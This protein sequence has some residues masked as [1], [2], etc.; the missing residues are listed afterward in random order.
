MACGLALV[1]CAG[2][3]GARTAWAHA[4]LVASTPAGGA[5]LE[6]P[7]VGLA[8]VFS[9]PVQPVAVQVFDPDGNRLAGVRVQAQGSRLQV[10]LPAAARARG[11]YLLSWR[12][13]SADGHPVSGVL[14]YAV[15]AASARPMVPD[16]GRG[17]HRSAIW[18]ARWLTYVCIVV[19]AGAALFRPGHRAD[20][21]AWTR[22]WAGAGLGLLLLD[23]ALQGLDLVG[24][25]WAGLGSSASWSAALAGSYAWTLGLLALALLLAL[26]TGPAPGRANLW[27]AACATPLI[28]AGAFALSGHAAT[29]SP[30]W[31]ARPSVVLHVLMVLAWIGSLWPLARALRRAPAAAVPDLRL[32]R[33]YSIAITWVVALLVASGIVLTSLQLDR[34]SDAWRTGYGR[35]LLAKLV[36]VAWLLL[37]AAANRWRWTGPA[38]AGSGPALRAL[39]RAVVVELVL[40]AV[41]LAVVALWRFTPPPRAMAAVQVRAG[42]AADAGLAAPVSLQD[43]RLQAR[44]TPT[45]GAQ[46]WV[47]ALQTPQGTAFAAQDVTLVL[48]N[49][50]AG[51]GAMRLAAQ[52]A[53]PGQWRVAVPVL[54]LVGRWQP[55]L[56]VLIDDFDQIRL[57]AAPPPPPPPGHVHGSD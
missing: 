46:P 54:P 49:P 19:V 14:D 28:A 9:E 4:A 25:G 38:L 53:A 44:I 30:Q 51:I 5:I 23:L 15:G 57:P 37:V 22:P 1:L 33:H 43:E 42:Q 11:S 18:L 12:V 3:L 39:R 41:V 24:A 36:L 26:S 35:V 2:L 56:L 20:T 55:T 7:P 52:Q 50:Q 13:A 17:G 31:L 47:I 48:H 27:L 8:L 29:A 40:A 21:L 45:V 34:P 32:L 10:V 16:A 6:R